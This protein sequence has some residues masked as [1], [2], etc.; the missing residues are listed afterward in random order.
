MSPT[1]DHVAEIVN[2]LRSEILTGVLKPDLPLKQESIAARFQVSR[3]PVREAL[4]QLEMMGFVTVNQNRRTHVAPT[5][6]ADFLEIYDMRIAA[7]V[8]AIRSA[9]PH[10]TNA[11]IDK[12][13]GFHAKILA[14]QTEDFG[15]LN[16]ALHMALYEPSARPRLLGHI[17]NLGEAADRYTF[18]CSVDQAFRD[19]SN[20]EHAALI[21]ACYA[22]DEDAAAQC[23]ETHIRDA[24]DKFSPEF[25]EA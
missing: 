5:S 24:R 18:M 19:K 16:T 23:L 22:R 20:A 1:P 15:S 14:G 11:Q 2:Q 3:M 10:L 8:L 6:Q 25:K 4:R 13:S 17:Q 12:A 7:E 9:M 21:D